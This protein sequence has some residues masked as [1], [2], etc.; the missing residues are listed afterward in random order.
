MSLKPLV[1]NLIRRTGFD[2]V[3]YQP[4]FHRPPNL[5]APLVRDHLAEGRDFFFVQIGAHDGVLD[6]SLKDLIRQH[7]L[8]GL[9]V[10]PLPDVFET[11]RRNYADQPQLMFARVAITTNGVEPYLYRVRQGSSVH[12]FSQ[13]LASFNRDHLLKEGVPD[14]DI[15]RIVVPTTTLKDLLCTHGVRDVTLLQSDTEGFDY[16]IVRS[17]LDAGIRPRFLYYEHCHLSPALQ[18]ECKRLLD[19]HGYDFAEVGK[20]TIAVSRSR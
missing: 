17:A 12:Q 19:E 10:E 4:E 5:L 18:W 8:R 2:V 9:L 16:E 14:S 11:L 1:K 20:D 3:R 13:V 15:E 6:D 7:R